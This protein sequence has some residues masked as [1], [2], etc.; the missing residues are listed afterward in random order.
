MINTP[1]PYYFIGLMSGTSLDGIDAVLVDFSQNSPAIANTFHKPLPDQLRKELINLCNPGENEIER[2]GRCDT[3]I[4]HEFADAT[5]TLISTSEIDPNLVTAIGSHGQTI[6][7]RPNGNNPFTLQ[8]GDPSIIANKTG[9]CTIADFRRQD[10]AAGGQGAPL[11]PAFHADIFFSDSKNRAILNIGGMANLT[12]LSSDKAKPVTGF[13][14]G[15]GNVLIDTWH[16][17]HH[18]TLYDDKGQ[19]AATGLVNEVLL[20][21][22]LS[23][24][25]LKLSPPKSTGRELFNA[26]WLEEQ[27]NHFNQETKP[28][29]TART[30][31]EY[32]ARTIAHDLKNYFPECEEVFVCG[33]GAQNDLLMRQLAQSIPNCSLKSTEMLGISPDWVEAVAFA[34]L[35]KQ[36]IE[37]KPGNLPSVTGATHQCILGGIYL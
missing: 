28:E 22:L 35:A 5:N 15:P 9:I 13:D 12:L 3:A 11:V 34:W 8:I 10:I 20:N 23:E 18:S 24:D 30:L 7:H 27:L 1:E 4:A 14:T 32:T 2:M 29:D 17:E 6:R 37:E 25:Y 16:Q 31:V 36:R 33:G 21:Q 26:N 19:W